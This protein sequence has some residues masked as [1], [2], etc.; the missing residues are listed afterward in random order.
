MKNPT[1]GKNRG[2]WRVFSPDD[3]ACGFCQGACQRRSRMLG[4]PHEF[5]YRL[6]LVHPYHR[7]GCGV[8]NSLRS[9]D[10]SGVGGQWS[11]REIHL[12]RETNLLWVQ[13]QGG[14][15]S[16]AVLLSTYAHFVPTE[17][18]GYA[19]VLAAPDGTKKKMD[20]PSQGPLIRKTI[21]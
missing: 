7:T 2:S 4:A 5:K 12:S 13:Q 17:I 3:L 1:R 14:W 11:S 9:Q 10:P 21:I 19:D 16:P 6:S 15:T 8:G 18:G 20:L